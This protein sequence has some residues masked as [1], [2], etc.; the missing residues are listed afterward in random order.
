MLDWRLLLRPYLL[1]WLIDNDTLIDEIEIEDELGCLIWKPNTFR[2]ICD[3]IRFDERTLLIGF[4]ADEGEI[5]RIARKLHGLDSTLEDPSDCNTQNVYL[6]NRQAMDFVK[7][8]AVALI[9]DGGPRKPI[10]KLAELDES[11]LV[12]NLG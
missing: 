9:Y 12:R 6:L 4:S 8:N 5:V 11:A 3:Q 1:D 10:D 2:L 7:K